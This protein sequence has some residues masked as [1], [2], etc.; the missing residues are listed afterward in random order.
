M[1]FGWAGTVAH[2]VSPPPAPPLLAAAPYL[3]GPDL[4]VKYGVTPKVTQSS[5]TPA[6]PTDSILRDALAAS[7]NL[8]DGK[9]YEVD[10]VVQVRNSDDSSSEALKH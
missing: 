5:P 9:R 3:L 4:A 8:N 6:S 10:F 2:F 1:V 7:L